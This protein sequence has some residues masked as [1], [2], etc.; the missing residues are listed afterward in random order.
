MSHAEIADAMSMSEKAVKSLLFRSREN[1]RRMLEPQLRRL[2]E[3]GLQTDEQGGE[4]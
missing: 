1:L 3:A 4:A 2:G